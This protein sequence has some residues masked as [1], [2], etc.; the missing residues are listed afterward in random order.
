MNMQSISFAADPENEA[1][2]TGGT[3]V[4]ALTADAAPLPGV[5][6]ATDAVPP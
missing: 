5:L 2:P 6:H 1:T 3:V 4:A